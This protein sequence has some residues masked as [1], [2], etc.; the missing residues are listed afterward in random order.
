ME[1]K[2]ELFTAYIDKELSGEELKSFESKLLKD[3]EFKTAF[4]DFKDVHNQLE[5]FHSDERAEF[6]QCLQD[7]G[8]QFEADI[9]DTTSVRS[10]S[11]WK[12][13]VAAS[14]ILAIG[15][16][17]YINFSSLNYD[18][19]LS[20]EQISLGL[21]SEATELSNQAEKAFNN[22]DYEQAIVY[23]DQLLANDVEQV[24]IQYYKAYA[25][26]KTKD[27][28]E[29]LAS[30]KL[31]TQG[32]SAYVDQANLLK[33]ILYFE[34]KN[35]SKAKES[36]ESISKSSEYYKSAQKLLKKIK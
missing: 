27:Y 30:L 3:L 15:W 7:V 23:F 33:G 5:H 2:F 31:I 24:Q 25:L 8:K 16:F 26:F 18:K 4:E 13:A 21:R 10:F 34:N 17:S 9:E 35:F 29:A 32:S 19:M 22:K 28:K 36:L 20:Q 1:N 6:A 11:W 12:T 14:V